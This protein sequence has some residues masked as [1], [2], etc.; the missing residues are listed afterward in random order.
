[1]RL[2]GGRSMQSCVRFMGFE[3]VELF[4]IKCEELA[5]KKGLMLF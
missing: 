4:Q 3:G 5:I 1:M 2:F